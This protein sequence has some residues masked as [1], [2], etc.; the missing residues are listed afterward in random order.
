MQ[1][2][3]RTQP[4][5]QPIAMPASAGEVLFLEGDPCDHIYE[6]RDGIA[7]GVIVSPDGD[8]QIAAFFFNGDQIGLPVSDRYRFTAEAVTDLHYVR[9]SRGSWNEA[10]IRSCR[11]EGRLLPSICAEQ[12]PILRRGIIIGRSG[13][14]TRVCAFLVSIADR[15]ASDHGG[16]VLP[17][18]Q[19]DIAAYLATTPES[20]CRAF[21]QLREMGVIS[22]ARRDRLVICD[23]AEL[24]S[25]AAGNA[26]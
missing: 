9:C 24:E 18:P 10:L 12:D 16:L 3:A 15:L 7:R 2:L 17:L 20:V 26:D 11:D 8:R 6:L 19:A 23:H 14:L 25:M 21:R 4:G 5:T 1:S 22:M 13:V